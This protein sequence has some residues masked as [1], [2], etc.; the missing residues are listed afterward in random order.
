MGVADPREF[1]ARA[2]RGEACVIDQWQLQE[3]EKVLRKARVL[4]YSTGIDRET[5][6]CLFV[7]PI[8]SVEEGVAQALERHGPDA[9]IAVIPEGPYVLACLADDLVGCRTV[10]EMASV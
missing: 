8:A 10:R 4:N 7:E 5:Q 6:R 3:M 2:L 1:M 9:T